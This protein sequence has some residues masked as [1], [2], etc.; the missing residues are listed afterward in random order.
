MGNLIRIE[1]IYYYKYLQ[2]LVFTAKFL[3]SKLLTNY[4][5]CKPVNL[6]IKYP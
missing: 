5:L 4:Y 3:Y 1:H 6:A 2:W